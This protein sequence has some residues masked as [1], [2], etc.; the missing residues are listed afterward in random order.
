MDR[1]GG[2]QGSRQGEGRWG[3][4]HSDFFLTSPS[5]NRFFRFSFF[6]SSFVAEFF[7]AGF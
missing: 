7:L 5:L 3:S 2:R 1:R 4:H 6:P